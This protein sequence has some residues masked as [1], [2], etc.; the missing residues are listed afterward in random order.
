M[1]K[2][3]PRR[4]A[5]RARAESSSCPRIP[6]W[7]GPAQS[8]SGRNER[9]EALLPA[10]RADEGR[11]RL[12]LP[13]RRRLRAP[14]PP[15]AA[16]PHEALPERRR[17]RF[18]PPEARAREAPAV[19]GRDLRA[20]PERPLDRLRDRRQRRRARLGREPRL[21]R[22]PHVV[23]ARAGDREAGLPPDRPRSDERRPVAVRARDRAR[24]ARGDGRARALVV[25]EDV[26]VDGDA[27]PGADPA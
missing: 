2:R 11:P 27:R 16:L 18:L 22:A 9:R 13:R 7:F 10:A 1:P 3:P 23:V 14:P 17:R 26:R 4:R 24:R 15:P 19:R 12:V 20:L 8:Y 25:S 6:S 21:H 5:R